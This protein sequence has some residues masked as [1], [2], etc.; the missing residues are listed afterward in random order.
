MLEDRTHLSLYACFFF[1]EIN[2]KNK[3]NVRKYSEE[4][5]PK[6]NAPKFQASKMQSNVV[7]TKFL[8]FFSSKMIF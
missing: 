3:P 1:V 4:M 2:A 6:T 5:R 7:G 8:S